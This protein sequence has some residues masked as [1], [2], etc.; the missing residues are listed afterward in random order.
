MWREFFYFNRFE[1]RAVLLISTVLVILILLPFFWPTQNQQGPENDPELYEAFT[2]Y[3]N[4]LDMQQAQK[5]NQRKWFPKPFQE[6]TTATATEKFAFDPNTVTASEMYRL[7]IPERVIRNSL[8]YREKGGK[9]QQPEDFRKIYGMTDELFSELR[10]YMTVSPKEPQIEATDSFIE[11]PKSI[12]T[13]YKYPEG[14]IVE[15]NR[16]DTTELKKIPG[17]GQVTARRIIAYRKR[18]G[19]FYNPQQLIEIDETYARF[20]GWFRT[21]TSALRKINLNKLSVSQLMKHPYLNFYQ[22]KVIDQ[23]RKK[24]G[25]IQSLRDLSLYEEFSE[26]D[27]N[28]LRPYTTF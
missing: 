19:G 1:R 7:G 17:I 27:L 13:F 16:A 10:P 20:T 22:A 2:A 23:Y 28:R 4:E 3:Q 6:H 15:L 9:F 25:P 24:R 11:Q 8:K 5:D 21:D 12:K 26:Q 14:T 18:L